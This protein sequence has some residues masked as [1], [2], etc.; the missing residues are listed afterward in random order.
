MMST[1]KKVFSWNVQWELL[2]YCSNSNRERQTLVKGHY[3]SIT[4]YG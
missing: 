2:S 1:I 3:T 4:V